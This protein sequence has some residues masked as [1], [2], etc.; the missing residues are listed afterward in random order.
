MEQEKLQ[1]VV[2]EP[3]DCKTPRA[4]IEPRKL[5]T[6]L[7]VPF[8]GLRL[9]T[10]YEGLAFDQSEAEVEARPAV[11]QRLKWRHLWCYH[12]LNAACLLPHL[13]YNWLHLL[14][15]CFSLNPWLLTFPILL[16]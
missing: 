15:F 8:R 13:A 1:Q 12:R 9:V 3:P 14:V 7:L 5:C 4:F 11:N 2:Q 6:T 16:P 10:P